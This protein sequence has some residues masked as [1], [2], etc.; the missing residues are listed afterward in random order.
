MTGSGCHFAG[1]F[2]PVKVAVLG[3]GIM[4]A[5]MARN[6]ARAGLDVTAWNRSREK[7]EPLLRDG[8]QIAESPSDAVGEADIV[9]TMLID[10]DAVLEVMAGDGGALGAIQESAVWAQMSTVGLEKIDEC[11]RLA[12]ERHLPIVDAP[13]LG[14]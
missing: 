6:M 9:V 14:T 12:A 1:I 11:A 5:P 13:V 7:T 4:G 10:G 8:I 2:A 3:T